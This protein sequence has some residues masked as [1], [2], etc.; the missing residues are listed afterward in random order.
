MFEGVRKLVTWQMEYLVV[1][2]FG[3]KNWR[4]FFFVIALYNS[5]SARG[6]WSR[7]R[8]NGQ[9]WQKKNSGRRNQPLGGDDNCTFFNNTKHIMRHVWLKHSIGHDVFFKDEGLIQN[10]DFRMLQQPVNPSC[11]PAS[12]NFLGGCIPGLE[13]YLSDK[14]ENTMVTPGTFRAPCLKTFFSSNQ[15]QRIHHNPP[16]LTHYA[17]KNKVTWKSSCS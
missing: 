1:K 3:E 9:A 11:N 6:G 13:I 8:D 7:C 17:S 5:C 10:F 12:R 4:F 14:G 2:T 16:T 15:K